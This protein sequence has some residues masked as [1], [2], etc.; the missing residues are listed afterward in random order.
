MN[1]GHWSRYLEAVTG[2]L[3]NGKGG[4]AYAVILLAYH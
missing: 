2:A 3:L 4:G 1:K